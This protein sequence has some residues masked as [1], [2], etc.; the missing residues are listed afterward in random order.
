MQPE[1]HTLKFTNPLACQRFNQILCA[2][3]ALTL[4]TLCL[5]RSEHLRLCPALKIDCRWLISQASSEFSS[6]S[7]IVLYAYVYVII[8]VH[9]IMLRICSYSFVVLG[10]TLVFIMWTCIV[11]QLPHL[12]PFFFNLFLAVWLL[13]N[14]PSTIKVFAVTFKLPVMSRGRVFQMWGAL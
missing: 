14:K 2:L 8:C 11:L 9:L 3:E 13:S 6:S 4:G 1:I 7:F 12:L 5:K 10:H